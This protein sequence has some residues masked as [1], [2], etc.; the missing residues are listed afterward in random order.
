MKNH[1]AF[2]L[3]MLLPAILVLANPFWGHIACSS[4]CCSTGLSSP[5][6]PHA[7][8][9]TDD[10]LKHDCCESNESWSDSITCGCVPG[11]PVPNHPVILQPS[12]HRTDVASY[13]LLTDSITVDIIIRTEA[14]HPHS[15]IGPPSQ[16]IYLSLSSLRC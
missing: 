15:G 1:R 4:A 9:V 7:G 14:M 13:P 5:Q 16:S 6:N 2:Q 12:N 11:E 3:F 10:G 8:K